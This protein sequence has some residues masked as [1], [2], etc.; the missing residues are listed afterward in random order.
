M[1]GDGATVRFIV[2]RVDNINLLKDLLTRSIVVSC[3]TLKRISVEWI[4]FSSTGAWIML[5]Y[6]DF[7]AGEQNFQDRLGT[8]YP[9]I[10]A[11]WEDVRSVLIDLA[12]AGSLSASEY[13]VTIRE[14]LKPLYRARLSF[15][16]ERLNA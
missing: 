9:N 5:F 7:K 13:E 10:E 3:R 16:H 4:D 14:Q 11:A 2:L 12:H 15:S 6:F 8:E 1:A